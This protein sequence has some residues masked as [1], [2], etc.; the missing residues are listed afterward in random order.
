M[1]PQ[2]ELEVLQKRRKANYPYHG[3]D[4]DERIAQLKK[5]VEQNVSLPKSKRAKRDDDN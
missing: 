4:V 2:T 3:A 5:V 1:D